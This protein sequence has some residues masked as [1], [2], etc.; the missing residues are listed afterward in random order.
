MAQNRLAM[1]FLLCLYYDIIMLA[2]HPKPYFRI[3]TIK[4]YYY[5]IM[6]EFKII[7]IEPLVLFLY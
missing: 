2:G 7:P 1:T 6:A 5:I 4:R 3:L